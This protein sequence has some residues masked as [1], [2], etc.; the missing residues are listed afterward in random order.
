[1]RLPTIG[2][3]PFAFASRALSSPPPDAAAPRPS[4]PFTERQ[5][6]DALAQFAT[7]VTVICARAADGGYAG[8]TANSFNA[9]S[10]VPP[11]ILWSLHERANTLAAFEQAER[12]TVNVLAHDQIELARRFSEPHEDRFA[13]VPFRLGIAD[14]PLID[15]CVAW[16]ECRRFAQQRMGDHMLFVGEVEHCERRPGVGLVFV[17]GGYAMPQDL[18]LP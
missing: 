6:R 2:H 16:L 5:F 4:P 13:G 8:F 14:A 7:G 3:P 10:L 15:G 17:H 1:M 18:P 11:L 12:Y 9:L